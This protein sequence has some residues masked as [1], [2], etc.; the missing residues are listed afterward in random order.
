MSV[1]TMMSGVP[2]NNPTTMGLTGIPRK[3]CLIVLNGSSQ[4]YFVV[5]LGTQQC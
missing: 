1:L 3:Y 5:S 2:Y 4:S